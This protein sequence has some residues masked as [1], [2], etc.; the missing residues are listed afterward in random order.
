MEAAV[1]DGAGM[2]WQYLREHG[3]TTLGRLRQG[4]KLSDQLLLMSVGWL[5]REGKVSIVQQGRTVKLSL[6]EG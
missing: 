3:Q 2:I 4:T 1:G 5:A 6:R